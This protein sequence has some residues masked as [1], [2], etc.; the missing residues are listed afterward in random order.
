MADEKLTLLV[1]G[2][3]GFGMNIPWTIPKTDGKICTSGRNITWIE[4][5]DEQYRSKKLS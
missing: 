3:A 2:S 1:I 4:W 5:A